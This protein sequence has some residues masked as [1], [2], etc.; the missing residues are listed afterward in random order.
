MIKLQCEI[1]VPT[2]TLIWALPTGEMLEFGIL[3]DV[4][5]VRT[6]SDNAYTATL[7]GKREDNDPDT[8]RFFFS[9]TLLILEPVNQTTLTC[10][11]GGGAD[12]VEKSAI[13]TQSGEKKQIASA[14]ALWMRS[15]DAPYLVIS[16]FVSGS[17][18]T[19]IVVVPPRQ[20]L[21]L[22]WVKLCCLLPSDSSNY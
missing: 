22:S 6:S 18:H 7:T 9:S 5:F 21:V 15:S 14:L 2:T 16:M 4:G 11:G 10:T 1:M 13:I 3:K 17:L 8:D 12:P 20:T 19:T